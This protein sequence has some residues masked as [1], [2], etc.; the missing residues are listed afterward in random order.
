MTTARITPPLD[1]LNR[2]FWTAGA[3]NELRI[4]R[5]VDCCRW[6]F[7]L[8][9]RCAQCGGSTVYETTSGRGTV[10]SYTTN[11]HPYNPAVP[12]PYNISIVE[13]VDQQDLRF[14]TNVL[15]CP[16]EDLHIGMPVSVAFEQHGYVFVPIFI[17]EPR[18]D[19]RGRS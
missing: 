8:S 15:G 12:L 14:T 19:Q 5:C 18:T 2:E 13:L 9:G 4:T 6:V 7:P 1:Q 17:P 16:P 11:A 3:R 10:F